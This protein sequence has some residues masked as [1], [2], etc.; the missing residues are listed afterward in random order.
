MSQ[1]HYENICYGLERTQNYTNDFKYM[2]LLDN[3]NG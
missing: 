3:S 2:Y 1:D